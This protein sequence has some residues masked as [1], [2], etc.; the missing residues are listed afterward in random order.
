MSRMPNFH[1]LAQLKTTFTHNAMT[2]MADHPEVAE[3]VASA[4]ADVFVQRLQ[5]YTNSATANSSV[6]RSLGKLMVT[7]RQSENLE[8][9]LSSEA[10]LLA[11]QGPNALER[12]SSASSGAAAG[13]IGGGTASVF[14]KLANRVQLASTMEQDSGY[15]KIY[16]EEARAYEVDKQK[17][18]LAWKQ[19]QRKANA[20]TK[21]DAVVLAQLGY[22]PLD[23]LQFRY[24][25]L[26]GGKKSLDDVVRDRFLE[27]HAPRAARYLKRERALPTPFANDGYMKQL[28]KRAEEHAQARALLLL[29]GGGKVNP[30]ELN[31]WLAAQRKK[32]Y[33]AEIARFSRYAPQRMSDPRYRKRVEAHFNRQLTIA[34]K[35]AITKKIFSGKGFILF[36][37]NRQQFNQLWKAAF[38][39][40]PSLH[41]SLPSETSLINNINNLT[42]IGRG[43][44][45]PFRRLQRRTPSLR[46]NSFLRF[47]RLNPFTAFE[48]SF[49][50]L[51]IIALFV[52]L[53]DDLSGGM[54][55]QTGGQSRQDFYAGLINCGDPLSNYID[56]AHQDQTE[57]VN[58]YK[59][60]FA[61]KIDGLT[62]D[63][64]ADEAS[65]S[66]QQVQQLYHYDLAAYANMW[67]PLCLI[68]ERFPPVYDGSDPKKMSDLARGFLHVLPKGDPYAYT[69]SPQL[70]SRII[71]QIDPGKNYCYTKTHWY[72]VD[73][74]YHEDSSWIYLYNED[75]CTPDQLK[76]QLARAYADIMWQ[77]Y[78]GVYDYSGGHANFIG[79]VIS[80][81][82][83]SV[84]L[85]TWH[86]SDT[87]K[88]QDCFDDMAGE[89]LVWPYYLDQDTSKPPNV[90]AIASF[91]NDFSAGALKPFYDFAKNTLF[92]GIDFFTSS[93]SL[94]GV[95]CPNPTPSDPAGELKKWGFV[96]YFTDPNFTSQNVKD[97]T[98]QTYETI[99]LLEQ[100][101]TWVTLVGASPTHLVHI[102]FAQQPKGAGSGCT[103]ISTSSYCG[104]AP[105]AAKQNEYV[106]F[107]FGFTNGGNDLY[108]NR[109]ITTHELGH[110]IQDQNQNIYDDFN[111]KYFK[112]AAKNPAQYL[113]YSLNCPISAA[114]QKA[115]GLDPA[116]ECLSDFMAIYVDYPHP[117]NGDMPQ[118][119]TSFNTDP[120]YTTV[121]QF[122]SSEVFGGTDFNAA[123]QSLQMAIYATNLN[124]ALA[125]S[126]PTYDPNRMIT[127]YG[128]Q[129]LGGYVT[130]AD[131]GCVNSLVGFQPK[132][133]VIQAVKD[134]IA[135]FNGGNYFQC[136]GFVNA[137]TTGVG[138]PITGAGGGDAPAYAGRVI[139]GFM[140]FKY[141]DGL[142][143]NIGDVIIW[144]YG[145][146]GH[147]AIV[148]RVFPDNSIT[149]AEANGGDGSVYSPHVSYSAWTPNVKG[150]QRPLKQ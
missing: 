15:Q 118:S 22:S 123:Q 128:Q 45:N 47:L 131:V 112:T 31:D 74:N 37:R 77:I 96:L 107:L 11:E 38:S 30:L 137:A 39:S 126:C 59:K 91:P 109:F 46:S 23:E 76:F 49:F 78:Q 58:I 71:L 121:Y 100:S 97:L 94:S 149:I 69:D 99:C 132:P 139:P 105:S 72:N 150:W 143:P 88:A 124:N 27:E 122:I 95:T 120:K 29:R 136:V 138:T 117:S 110:V 70:A 111:A 60:R 113:P 34:R 86:C 148:T 82:P 35:E 8:S 18:I 41:I 108:Y 67:D 66:S 81:I 7:L 144:D 63:I 52:L 53:F 87:K 127:Y 33:E 83:S 56:P 24:G 103:E 98:Q 57:Y 130:G 43:S 134:G 85:P 92:N 28:V 3:I 36:I 73:P 90:S 1:D 101:Q 21:V 65:Q 64:T 142:V 89:Y 125:R 119:L 147:I 79:D 48:F 75:H 25:S 12:P 114:W 133:D 102:V 116:A 32:V 13:F 17:K 19:Q 40:L 68:Y 6:T 5:A 140:W 26:G 141:Q 104:T 61:I 54:F 146:F 51:I 4:S 20:S 55:W 93:N 145:S 42:N 14:S 50:S 44:R 129:Y 62:D 10:Q 9:Q 115:N 80:K 2:L 84:Q 106:V 135:F 16:E